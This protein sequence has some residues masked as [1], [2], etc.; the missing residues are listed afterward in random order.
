MPQSD[1][2]PSHYRRPGREQLPQ[3]ELEEMNSDIVRR[4]PLPLPTSPRDM[5]TTQDV[6]RGR[7]LG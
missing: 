4:K 5:Q 2:L 1:D 6:T 3:R 7:F